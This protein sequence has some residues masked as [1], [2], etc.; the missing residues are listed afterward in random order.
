MLPKP[1]T[2]TAAELLRDLKN[3]PMRVILIPAPDPQHSGHK[4]RVVESRPPAWYFRTCYSIKGRKTFKRHRF[5]TALSRIKRGY[6]NDCTY[7]QIAMEA[8]KTALID[9]EDF[10]SER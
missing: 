9:P 4:I 1:I 5:V 8:I 10:F 7:E 2:K 3:N 6:F